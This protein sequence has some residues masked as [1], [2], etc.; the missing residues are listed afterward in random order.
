[1]A[2][3]DRWAERR[4]EREAPS[5]RMGE[6]ISSVV[7]NAI[8][9][10]VLNRLPDWN[11]SVLVSDLYRQVLWAINL[12]LGVHVGL[13]FFLIFYHPLSLHYLAGVVLSGVGVIPLARLVSVFPFS[14]PAQ[15]SDWLTPLVKVLLILG[16]VG[17]AIGAAVNLGK[18]VSTLL[19]GRED[20]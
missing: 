11:I 19:R 20:R 3:R 18:L 13:N 12:S 14:F 16:L 4:R 2:D 10:Y 17:A 15:L 8:L 6:Y 5:R 9:I 7:A 1:M